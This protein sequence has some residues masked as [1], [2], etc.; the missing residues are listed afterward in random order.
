MWWP[1]AGVSRARL[2]PPGLSRTLRGRHPNNWTGDAAVA[3]TC[4]PI[5]IG[6]IPT[7]PGVL[8]LEVRVTGGGEMERGHPV[9]S[10]E[11]SYLRLFAFTIRNQS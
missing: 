6:F 4:Q 8:K 9:R 11:E 7:R 10:F 5:A 1:P 2:F 3:D